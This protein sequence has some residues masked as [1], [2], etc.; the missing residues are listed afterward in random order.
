MKIP[1]I[2]IL[3][4]TYY[5]WI[6]AQNNKVLGVQDSA[7][8][9]NDRIEALSINVEKPTTATPT[10]DISFNPQPLKYQPV[11]LVFKPPLAP[12]KLESRTLPPFQWQ[13]IQN[14]Y[15]KAGFGL[16]LTPLLRIYL[17]KG[18]DKNWDYG[19]DIYLLA[20]AVGHAEQANFVDHKTGLRGSYALDDFTIYAKAQFQYYWFNTFGDSLLLK[21]L[22]PKNWQDSI[23]R[24]FTRLQ[25]DLGIRSNEKKQTFFYDFGLRLAHYGER[26][27][28]NEFHGSILPQLGFQLT[29]NLNILLGSQLTVSNFKRYQEYRNPISESGLFTDIT[30]TLEYRNQKIK[31]QA[32]L[33]FNYAKSDTVSQTG[34]Y[35]IVQVQFEA[36]EKYLTL[37]ASFTGQTIYNQRFQFS[38]INPYLSR[39]ARVLPTKEPFRIQGG[40]SG[41]VKGLSYGAEVYFR[42]IENMP[43]FFSSED[44][45]YLKQRVKRGEFQVYYDKNFKETGFI[46]QFNYSHKD[47]VQS[48]IKAEIR[49]FALNTLPKNFQVPG[50]MIETFCR[51]QLIPQL[52]SY[53]GLNIIGPRIMSFDKNGN[54]IEQNAFVDLNLEVDYQ[55]L[56][57]FSIFVLVNNLFNSAYYRWHFYR[58]R[59]F[60]LKAGVTFSF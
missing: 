38:A 3:L 57:R 4:C 21:E 49:S 44:T 19:A 9:E 2:F 40:V 47:K 42:K 18:R 10:L 54:F 29:D 14:N 32:G 13:P 26:F 58:E 53:A 55:L 50:F 17:A 20:S 33:R 43:I 22:R 46:L 25:V 56:K 39:F 6:F 24:Y 52:F 51:F 8:L 37:Q 35:P 11:E 34:F 5:F 15:I 59:P 45:I 12:L 48:G 60:D 28:L 1:L 23:R 27:P 7:T 31:G 36:L 16:F 41:G 30:P